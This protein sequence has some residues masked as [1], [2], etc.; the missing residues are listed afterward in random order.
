[1]FSAYFPWTTWK[2]ALGLVLVIILVVAATGG[3][4]E[5]ARKSLPVKA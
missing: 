5:K 3:I 4:I 2:Q 1:M